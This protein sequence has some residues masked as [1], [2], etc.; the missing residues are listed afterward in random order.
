MHYPDK[1]IP[2]TLYPLCVSMMQLIS[3]LVFIFFVCVV[4]GAFRM[5]ARN[6]RTLTSPMRIA[7]RMFS[8]TVPT[9]PVIPV[10]LRSSLFYSSL[11][12]SFSL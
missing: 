3:A 10:I 1:E 2:V 12:I 6:V 4:E 8:A 9:P 5:T 7:T 11:S